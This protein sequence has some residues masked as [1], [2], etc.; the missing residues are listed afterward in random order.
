MLDI[1]ES[2]FMRIAE[3]II[4]AGQ[5]VREAFATYILKEEFEEG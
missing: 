3:A 1:A 2:C 5:S 4:A